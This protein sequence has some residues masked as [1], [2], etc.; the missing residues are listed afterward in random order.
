MINIIISNN[1]DNKILYRD[2]IGY[3]FG[4]MDALHPSTGTEGFWWLE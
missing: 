4:K 3:D 1:K 2:N